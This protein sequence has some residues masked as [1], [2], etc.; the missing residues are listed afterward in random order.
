MGWNMNVG[1]RVYGPFS[2]ESLKS[3]AAE[4]R[5]AATSL[6]CPEGTSEWRAAS[7]EPELSG[8]FGAA[9]KQTA[10]DDGL[11]AP[12]PKAK[13]AAAAPV[14]GPDVA[15]GKQAHF[16]IVIDTKSRTSP[17]FE[18]V[19]SSM[20][21]AFRLL[22]NLWILATMQT[23]NTVRNRLL[24]EL[25]KDDALFVVDASRGKAAWFNFGPE[26]DAR[27]RRVWQKAS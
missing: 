5:L 27:I 14:V 20:G 4:G 17:H 3:F 22:P 21:N 23:V 9:P 6:V 15:D 25:G 7:E 26:T 16:A 1:G 19:V 13:A 18:D 24:Q 2:L 11:R 10:S 8:L 12:A